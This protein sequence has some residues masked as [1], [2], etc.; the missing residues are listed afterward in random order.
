MRPVFIFILCNPSSALSDGCKEKAWQLLKSSNALELQ[1]E[2]LLWLRT[3][4][5]DNCL[6]TYYK[7]FGFTMVSLSKNDKDICIALL[8]LL[9]SVCISFLEHGFDPVVNLDTIST[10]INKYD[11]LSGNILLALMSEMIVICPGYYLFNV[12]QLCEC[13]LI[14]TNS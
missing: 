10:I 1:I 14:I 6:E 7:I 2:I 3:N 9:S 13:T 4:D 11:N 5:V 12:L 8:P